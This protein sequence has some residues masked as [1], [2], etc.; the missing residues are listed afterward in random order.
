M[1]VRIKNNIQPFSLK[2]I[3]NYALPELSSA[4]LN[5]EQQRLLW[6]DDRWEIKDNG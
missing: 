5:N 1:A 6:S 4:I 2:E 3:E